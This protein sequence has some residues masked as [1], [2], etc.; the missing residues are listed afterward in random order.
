MITTEKSAKNSN[1][2]NKLKCCFVSW[3]PFRFEFGKI[4]IKD[5]NNIK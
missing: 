3:K 2:L 4:K 1:K 5:G